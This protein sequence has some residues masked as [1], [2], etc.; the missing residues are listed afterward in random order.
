MLNPQRSIC[1][2]EEQQKEE[3]WERGYTEAEGPLV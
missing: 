3:A 1:Q 2:T